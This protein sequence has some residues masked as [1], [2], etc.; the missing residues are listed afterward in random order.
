MDY[1]L[2]K[3]IEKSND[4]ELDNY[5]NVLKREIQANNKVLNNT[6]S[7]NNVWVITSE[8]TDDP[9][10][11]GAYNTSNAV[12]Y[13]NK[14]ALT[15]NSSYHN[16]DSSGGD[17]TNFTSQC[18]YAGGIT[19]HKGTHLAGNCWYYTSANNRSSTWNGSNEFKNYI[20][21]TSS[22]IDKTN[23]SFSGVTHGDII[24]LT[25]SGTPY[26]SLIVTGIVTSGSGRTDLLV[27]AHSSNKKNASLQS[28]YSGNTKIYHHI[29]GT[30]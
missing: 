3:M 30:K 10:T 8:A 15:Y 2:E 13:A 20:N 16:F 12:T 4:L 27:C 9:P 6:Q 17:C 26:H 1:E 23:S 18:L 5:L 22:K 25:S 28:Y 7:S 29:K 19:M 21:S 11:R 14:Y 24:Q